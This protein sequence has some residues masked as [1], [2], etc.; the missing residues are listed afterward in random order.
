MNILTK[1]EYRNVSMIEIKNAAPVLLWKKKGDEHERVG[2]FP[3]DQNFDE[4]KTVA[5][6]KHILQVSAGEKSEMRDCSFPLAGL[7]LFCGMDS[8]SPLP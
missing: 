5:R 8:R 6:V 2:R 1:K 3:A 4:I 7:D